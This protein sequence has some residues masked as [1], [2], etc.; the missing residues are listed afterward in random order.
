MTTEQQAPLEKQSKHEDTPNPYVGPRSFKKTDTLY[1]RDQEITDLYYL[2]AA[3]RIVLMYS[4][5]G[6]GKT[7]LIQAGLI[8]R[9]ED[10][11][12]TVLPKPDE[13]DEEGNQAIRAGILTDNSS[14]SSNRYLA[15]VLSQLSPEEKTAEKKSSEL[16]EAIKK[17]L[18]VIAMMDEGNK[19]QVLI[20]D[21]FEEVLTKDRTDE[22]AKREFFQQLG[23]ILDSSPASEQSLPPLALFAMR[24]EYIAALEP[25]AHFIP[26]QFHNTF[27]LNLLPLDSALQ[28]IRQPPKVKFEVDYERDLLVRL[29]DTLR[30]VKEY[31][32]DDKPQEK[33]GPFIEP[34]LLQVVCYSL[35][36]KWKGKRDTQ[37]IKEKTIKLADYEQIARSK[38]LVDEALEDYYAEKVKAVAQNVNVSERHIRKWIG[39]RMIERG[40]RQPV[41]QGKANEEGIGSHVFEELKQ[42]Y[43]VRQEGRS[44]WY[45]LS[46]DRLVEPVLNDNKKNLWPWEQNPDLW[47]GI[48]IG[49]S[50][51][52]III[53]IIGIL[54]QAMIAG[55]EAVALRRAFEARDLLENDP[56]QAL[57]QA[58]EAANI[59]SGNI[60]VRD[61]LYQAILQSHL[62]ATPLILLKGH[63]AEV[64][65]AAYSPDGQY[66]VTASWDKIARVWNATTGE[67]KLV[68]RGHKDVLYSA[69][70]SP[71]GQRIV[72]ASWDNTARVWDAATGGFLFTL[73]H[74]AGVLGAVFSPDGQ[75]VATAGYDHTV[76]IW[77][78]GTSILLKTIV[79]TENEKLLRDVAFSPYGRWVAAASWDSTV[80]IWDAETGKQLYRLA[81]HGG[82]VSSVAFIPEDTPYTPYLV[83]AS[84]DKTAHIWEVTK[85]YIVA[86]LA[87]YPDYLSSEGRRMR[88]AQFSPD[89]QYV[90][91][92]G[93]DGTARI[94][95]WKPDGSVSL[96]LILRQ[97][98]EINSATFSPDGKYVVTASDD[99]TAQVWAI[100]DETMPV[101][102][103]SGGVYDAAF[104]PDGQH[105]VTG[106]QGESGAPV[107]VWEWD[108]ETERV[109]ETLIISGYTTTVNQVAFSP[110][111]QHIVTA[112]DDSTAR[113]WSITGNMTDAQELI[114]TH[115]VTGT[116]SVRS[117][118]FST[119]G[120]YVLTAIS[121]TVRIWDARTGRELYQQNLDPP[122]PEYAVNQAV[123]SPAST[124]GTLHI[125]VA[126]SNTVQVWDVTVGSDGQ[127]SH[128]YDNRL[129][130]KS[131]DTDGNIVGKQIADVAYSN[132]GEH[133]VTA[134]AD[135]TTR[136][137]DATTGQQKQRIFVNEQGIGSVAF[138]PYG[139]FIATAD[140]VS[141]RV[142][143][144]RTAEEVLV[145]RGHEGLLTSIAFS[146]DGRYILTT[147]ADGTARLFL[148]RFADVLELARQRV[149]QQR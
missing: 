12:Y 73:Q 130:L 107:Q 114:L 57:T 79:I 37:Q 50:L 123:F 55:N 3:E 141:V 45:E 132:D 15:A 35:W 92:A 19:R 117:V 29:L 119:D 60:K 42:A 70:Y 80:W 112:A 23:S 25:Y 63:T 41:T 115:N 7:S 1:G 134:G 144:I 86:K 126:I 40:M 93:E 36:E 145:I 138:S 6:A 22:G 27:R 137:W 69:E 109:S 43:L 18:S 106:G 10:E 95:E 147:S 67:E 89:G 104:S 149:E 26:T 34:L 14:M 20:F 32:P 87:P 47:K 135:G 59:H 9:L 52:I 72:T 30:T 98:A 127:L 105:I 31:G 113:V 48:G 24:E 2:L 65:S 143:D 85:E 38:S 118:D 58:T 77:D 94:W 124:D 88:D 139:K 148:A 71:D 28:A 5:S 78:S 101:M 108:R 84:W 142:W 54:W 49:I 64:K 128:T 61:V 16:A 74:P 96:K 76:R 56:Q 110:D 125:A 131:K 8:P 33:R 100:E 11:G 39:S 53:I 66:I 103:G 133:I 116:R 121:N 97:G 75:R 68:L 51:V 111:G 83:T 120:Q 62:Q 140:G 46:H 13:E 90:V 44:G 136:I 81:G 4:P 146:S 122:G 17:R 21:Q 91:T 99:N 102:R 82:N 129:T